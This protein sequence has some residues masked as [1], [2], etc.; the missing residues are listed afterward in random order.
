MIHVSFSLCRYSAIRCAS[1]VPMSSL[2]LQQT[3]EAHRAPTPEPEHKKS[4][5]N[6]EANVA[7][8]LSTKPQKGIM[9]MFANK[10]A[11]KTQDN[12]R[13]IKSEQK[14]DAPVV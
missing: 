11:P 13:D 9:G 14:E 1:A 2:E 12:G 3:R 10:T 6:G 7:S 4:G 8:K 5:M